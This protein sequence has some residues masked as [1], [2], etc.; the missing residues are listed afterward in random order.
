MNTLMSR[1]SFE[2]FKLRNDSVYQIQV[3][4]KVLYRAC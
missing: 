2:V 1:T 3:F 4:L